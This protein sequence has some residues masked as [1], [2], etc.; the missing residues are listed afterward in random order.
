[1]SLLEEDRALLDGFRRGDRSALGRVFLTYADEVARQVRAARVPEHDVES[2]VQDVFMKAF[3][4]AARQSYD[5]LRPYGAW[6]NTITRNLVIDRARKERRVDLRAP[7]DMPTLTSDDDPRAGQ[8]S[9]ELE[10]LLSTWRAGLDPDDERLFVV[11]FEE[12]QSLSQAA[13]TLGWSEI[14]VR[15]RDTALRTGLLSTLRAGGFLASA[16]VTIGASLL[17][18]KNQKK[19]AA[20]TPPTTLPPMPTTLPTT[21]KKEEA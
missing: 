15:K 1:M 16:Q 19:T 13:R 21:K 12:A 2:V 20:P 4:D 5:G 14:R 11:R 3:R 9:D 18:R 17:A 10:K 6:L 7:D 8:E